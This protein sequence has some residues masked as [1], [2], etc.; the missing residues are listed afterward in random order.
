MLVQKTETCRSCAGAMPE[1][2]VRVTLGNRTLTLRATVC[3]AC[4]DAGASQSSGARCKSEWQRLCPPHYQRDL[5]P[6]I[7]SQLWVGDVLG[8]QYKPPGSACHWGHGIRQDLG[9][10]A[11]FAAFAEG[12][13]QRRRAGCGDLPQRLEQS[14]ARGGNRGVR[15]TI[16]ARRGA[17]LGRFWSNASKCGG[18]RNALACPREENFTSASVARHEPI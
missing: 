3:R 14:C 12:A 9:D 11:S 8:W 13:P 1:A 16:G 17:L 10:V 6:G 2:T 7:L 5:P 18:E 15:S 4:A